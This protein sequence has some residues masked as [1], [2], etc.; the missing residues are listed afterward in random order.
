MFNNM[1]ATSG[2]YINYGSVVQDVKWEYYNNSNGRQGY[3]QCYCEKIYNE[4]GME[5][6]VSK[7]N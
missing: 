7:P 4:D 2:S 1:N 3:L 5:M 6:Y